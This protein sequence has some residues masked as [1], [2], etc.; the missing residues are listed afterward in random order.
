MRY[1]MNY[2]SPRVEILA[3]EVEDVIRTSEL[4]NGGSG[5]GGYGGLPDET[6]EPSATS[7]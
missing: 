5:T 6:N 7:F 3:L 1:V 4:T 2:E